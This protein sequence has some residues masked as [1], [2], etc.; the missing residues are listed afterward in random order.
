MSKLIVVD[1]ALADVDGL[2]A[3]AADYLAMRGLAL[4]LRIGGPN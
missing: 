3:A 1:T 2:I 4:E